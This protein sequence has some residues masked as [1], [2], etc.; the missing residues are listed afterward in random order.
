MMRSLGLTT[1]MIPFGL[2][3]ASGILVGRSIGQKSRA[4]VEHYFK[5][6][7]VA[8]LL[9]GCMQVVFMLALEDEII[10]AFTSSEQI[11]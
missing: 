3:I 8:S 11:A 10:A 4:K 2:S 5:S 6:C 7:M 1:F 9:L